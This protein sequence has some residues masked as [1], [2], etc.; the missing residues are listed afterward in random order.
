M[1]RWVTTL[2]VIKLQQNSRYSWQCRSGCIYQNFIKISMKTYGS[3]PK[4]TSDS[5]STSSAPESLLS[6][7]C[8][9]FIKFSILNISTEM[10]TNVMIM[11]QP[12]DPSALKDAHFMTFLPFPLFAFGFASFFLTSFLAFDFAFFFFSDIAVIESSAAKTQSLL[13]DG[14]SWTYFYMWY[15][16]LSIDQ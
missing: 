2:I 3:G 14:C 6:I 7:L 4:S 8:K 11:F 16:L 12:S 10:A 1:Y 13:G 15:V 9:S 5:T